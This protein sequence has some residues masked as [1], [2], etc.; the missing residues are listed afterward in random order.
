[1]KIGND[2]VRLADWVSLSSRGDAASTDGAAAKGGAPKVSKAEGSRPSG[3]GGPR[4]CR[5]CAERKYKDVSNDPTVSFQTPTAVSP[6]ESASAVSAHEQQHVAHDAARAEQQGMTATSIVS[7]H[8]AVCP[9]C[10]Q[11]YVS[12]GTTT[13]TYTKKAAVAGDGDDRGLLI[14]ATA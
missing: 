10:G 2:N 12:G 1:M 6:Q 9:E 3:R 4:Q 8:T 5:T 7:I 14:D 13:T 11:T